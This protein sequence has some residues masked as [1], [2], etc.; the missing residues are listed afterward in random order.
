MPSNHPSSFGGY[1]TI[2]DDTLI[3][4]DSSSN[5]PEQINVTFTSPASLPNLYLCPD[6]ARELRD[7]LT[8]ALVDVGSAIIVAAGLEANFPADLAIV[9]SFSKPGV[10]S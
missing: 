7:L 4:V 6:K 5:G 10:T 2:G 1:I 3:D 8:K 9:Q